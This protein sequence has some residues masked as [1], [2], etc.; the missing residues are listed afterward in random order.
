MN[1]DALHCIV[2]VYGPNAVTKLYELVEQEAAEGA[3]YQE[4]WDLRGF[5]LLTFAWKR[6]YDAGVRNLFAL[7]Q[8]IRQAQENPGEEDD[9]EYEEDECEEEDPVPEEAAPEDDEED[10]DQWDED[11][12]EE[13]K[14]E[15]EEAEEEGEEQK[16]EEMAPPPPKKLKRMKSKARLR[17]GLSKESSDGPATP[18]CKLPRASTE[19]SYQEVPTASKEEELKQ[20]MDKIKT[21]Q[22]LLGRIL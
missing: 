2:E 13:H 5:L 11:E 10:Y 3:F 1:A 15:A 18:A 20:I 6:Q 14:E 21:L 9:E 12:E 22:M 17:K 16:E 7:I 4:S 8:S 19:E